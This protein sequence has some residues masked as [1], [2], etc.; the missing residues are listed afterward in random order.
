MTSCHTLYCNM[1]T[2][3]VGGGSVATQDSSFVNVL[4]QFMG[5]SFRSLKDKVV[6]QISNESC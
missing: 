3:G 2:R 4:Y 1:Q 5:V 6:K